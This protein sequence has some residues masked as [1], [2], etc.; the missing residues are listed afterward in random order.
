MMV[1]QGAVSHIGQYFMK[2]HGMCQGE[3]RRS[4]GLF[5][6]QK[7][8]NYY[9]ITALRRAA[10]NLLSSRAVGSHAPALPPATKPQACANR[11]N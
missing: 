1:M 6:G 9:L 4:T 2:K 8:L 3:L 11:C 10:S 5:Q 7:K